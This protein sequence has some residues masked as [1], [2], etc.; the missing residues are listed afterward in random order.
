ML[1]QAGFEP[2]MRVL[3]A[4]CG[5][6]SFL[7]LLLEGGAGEVVALDAAPEHLQFIDEVYG[8]R[9]VP[10]V[11]VISALPVSSASMDGLWCANTLQ[12]LD[13]VEALETLREFAR[14]VRPGGIVAIKDVDMSAFK[15]LP[16]PAFLGAHL[17]EACATGADVSPQSIGSLRARG[18][19]GMMRESGL[20][21]VQQRCFVIERWG[22][23]DPDASRFWSEWLPYLSALAHQRRVPA[24]DLETWRQVATPALAEAFVARPDFYGCEMQVVC[25][26]RKPS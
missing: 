3:D 19:R 8:E 22:P 7:P 9:I 6:G 25:S 16:A 11:G 2:G 20:T 15:I 14:V 13:D 10:L 18:L 24:E 21:D 23:L 17:G 5:S 12:F 26:G 4:G 1:V